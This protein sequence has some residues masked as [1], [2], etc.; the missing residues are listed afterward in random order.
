MCVWAHTCMLVCLYAVQC[1]WK[2]ESHVYH[3]Q[4]VTSIEPSCWQALLSRLF[5]FVFLDSC[6]FLDSYNRG[7]WAWGF[8]TKIHI[9]EWLILSVWRKENLNRISVSIL[10]PA[11]SWLSRNT[12]RPHQHVLGKVLLAFSPCTRYFIFSNIFLGA[13]DLTMRFIGLTPDEFNHARI[14]KHFLTK[15]PIGK[16]FK[17]RRTRRSRSGKRGA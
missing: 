13:V 8:I 16:L 12:S 6:S 10:A 15:L 2:S 17:Q 3:W 11:P 14:K 7:L 1:K 5:L 4:E 9:W